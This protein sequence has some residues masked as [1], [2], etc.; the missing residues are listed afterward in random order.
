MCATW[1]LTYI[2][3]PR[4]NIKHN[5]PS[6]EQGHLNPLKWSSLWLS[7]TMRLGRRSGGLGT[8]P[9]PCAYGH[10]ILST[11]RN[12]SKMWMGGRACFASRGL[13]TFIFSAGLLFTLLQLWLSSYTGSEGLIQERRVQHLGQYSRGTHPE[14]EG[15]ALIR[16]RFGSSLKGAQRDSESPGFKSWQRSVPASFQYPLRR[17]TW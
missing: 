9:Q 8:T 5:T 12:K 13:D 3:H 2:N 14:A 17:S 10:K 11:T 16:L 7:S 4:L 15:R 6:Q 1:S